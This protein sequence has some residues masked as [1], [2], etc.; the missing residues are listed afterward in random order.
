MVTSVHLENEFWLAEWL[1]EVGGKLASF[2]SKSTGFEY[3]WQPP[4]GCW[5]RPEYG[6]TYEAEYATGF[7]ECFPTIMP[8]AYPDGPWRGAA[9]PDHGEV[10]ALPWQ[11]QAGRGHVDLWVEGRVL[12]YR[13]Y[14]RVAGDSDGSLSFRYELQ[15][16]GDD[17]L[18]YLWSAHPLFNARE[19]TTIALDGVPWVSVFE[20]LSGQLGEVGS[21]YNWPLAAGVN[22]SRPGHWPKAADKVF[23]GGLASGWVELHHEGLGERLLIEWQVEAAPCLGLWYNLH[24]WPEQAPHYNIGIEP[25]TTPS[26]L[27][28]DSTTWL[29]PR[30][31]AHWWM[32]WK[33]VR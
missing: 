21:R 20:S 25:C 17:V 29:A 6:I 3:L 19:D 26:D 18:H 28:T 2:R 23:L 13:L 10:W 4:D 14:K 5:P 33:M 31:T 16:R 9:M 32:R 27:L 30:E 24:G 7:D 11:W 22:L 1:P 15:N 8:C 12:P